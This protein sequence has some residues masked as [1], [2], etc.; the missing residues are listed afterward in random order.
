MIVFVSAISSLT[1]T[2]YNM[3]PARGGHR[4]T[5]HACDATAVAD[6]F[7]AV[8]KTARKN[9]CD[10][11]MYESLGRAQAAN[12]RALLDNQDLLKPLLVACP[13]GHQ[14][15]HCLALVRLE[16]QP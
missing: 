5:S 15:M 14:E 13:S 9:W 7:A 4:R 12:G 1:K 11:G 8:R 10:F 6:A 2:F 16:A 3:P